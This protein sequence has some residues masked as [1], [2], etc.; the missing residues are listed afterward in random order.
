M[1]SETNFATSQAGITIHTDTTP[2]KNI[3]IA[4]QLWLV[5]HAI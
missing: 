3:S 4:L 1:M 5:T 2:K